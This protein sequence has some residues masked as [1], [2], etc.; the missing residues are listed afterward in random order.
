DE[1][2]VAKPRDEPHLRSLPRVL[3]PQRRFGKGV[4]EIFA[5][6]FR[7]RQ[8]AP[9]VEL[10]RRHAT[11]RIDGEVVPLRLRIVNARRLDEFHVDSFGIEKK[12]HTRWKGREISLIKLHA[13]RSRAAAL[14]QSYA[15]RVTS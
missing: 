12:A 14:W 5:D 13:G 4:L 2:E 11:D 8:H 9:V 6:H 1:I 3:R 10:Q 7:F 15:T